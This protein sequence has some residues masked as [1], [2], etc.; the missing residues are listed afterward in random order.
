[1][2]IPY[3]VI[4]YPQK[5]VMVTGATLWGFVSAIYQ[6]Q[7]P[8]KDEEDSLAVRQSKDLDLLRIITYLEEDTLPDEY[9]HQGAI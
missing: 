7:L 1:M 9:P 4:R 8:A 3:H 5:T 6:P 2:L